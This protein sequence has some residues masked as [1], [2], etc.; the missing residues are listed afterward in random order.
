M[1]S[2]FRLPSLSS[3][4]L[5]LARHSWVVFVIAVVSQLT[6]V[7]PAHAAGCP[8]I[9]STHY[10]GG[11]KARA[12]F[13]Y[14]EAFDS[15]DAMTLEAWVYREDSGRCETIISHDYTKSW[16]LGFCD[17]LRFYRNGS[18]AD[19]DLDVPAGQWTHVAASYDGKTVRFFI[20]GTP[21]G[22]KPLQSLG[23]KVS[24][25]VI[26]GADPNGYA[27][28]GSLDEIRLWS[29]ARSA[30]EIQAGMYAELRGQPGLMA[31]WDTGGARE[32]VSNTTVLPG[33]GA[34][35]QVLGILPR[36]L[37][38]PRAAGPLTV[39]GWPK[40]DTEYIGAERLVIRYRD[41]PTAVDLVASLVY[42]DEPNDRALY[43]GL[44]G[45]RAPVNVKRNASFVGVALDADSSRDK[46]AQPA[47]L[48]MMALLD[49]ATRSY[50]G[51]GNGGWTEN[52][53]LS[54]RWAV[55]FSD[56]CS[57]AGNPPCMEFRIPET[58]L[59]SLLETDGLMI[60]HFGIFQSGD[61]FTGPSDASSTSPAT[62]VKATYCDAKPVQAA[63]RISGVVTLGNA[64]LKGVLLALDGPETRATMT[65]ESGKYSFDDLPVG[66]YRVLPILVGYEFNPASADLPGVK[67]DRV[68]N[69][70]AK[71]A[72]A[73]KPVLSSQK[74]SGTRIQFDKRVY[75]GGES[76]NGQLVLSY[77]GA[78]TELHAFLVATETGDVELMTLKRDAGSV[79]SYR[80]A[81]GVPTQ[82]AGSG[83]Y[84]GK[85]TVK[86]GEKLAL[87]YYIAEDRAHPPI[88]EQIVGDIAFVLDPNF[89]GAPVVLKPD[90]AVSSDE[91]TPPEGGK[92]IGTLIARNGWPV[93]LPV[94]ELIVTPRDGD[95]LKR[96]LEVT[97][98]T[99]VA[100]DRGPQ[101][102]PDDPASSYLVRVPTAK[103][104]LA[105][106]RQVRAFLGQQ[107]EVYGSNQEVLDLWSTALELQLKGFIV[108]ANPR[109]QFHDVPGVPSTESGAGDTAARTMQNEGPMNVPQL[110]AF[111]ALWDRDEVRVPVG[112]LDVG[113]APSPDLR[114][115][116]AECD[117]EAPGPGGM[118]CGPGRAFGAQRV[119]N[120]LF[121][122]KIWHGTGV[123]TTLGGKLN[124]RWTP[125]DGE[126][127]GR[128]GV[129]GQVVQP[130]LYQYGLGSYVFE[131]GA[132]MRQ[133]TIDGASVINISGGYPCRIVDSLGIGFN[134]CSEG[135]RAALCT[136]ATA[137]LATASA[138]VCAAAGAT[139]AIPFVGP[140]L[141]IPL[142]AACAVATGAT[143]AASSACFATL[144]LGDPRD[145]MR[146]GVRFAT[147]RGVAVVVS[148]GNRLDSTVLPPVIR[149]LINFSNQSIDDW[150]VFPAMI[151]PCIVAGAVQDRMPFAN[152]HFFGNRVNIWAPIVSPYYRPAPQETI[153][154]PNE[155]VREYL[156]GTSGA[157]PYVTGTIAAMQAVNPALNPRNPALSPRQRLAIPGLIRGIL[158]NSAWTTAELAAMTSDPA[159]AAQVTAGAPQRRH[160]INPLRAVQ[161]AAVGVI[162][163]F[164]P[165]G[166]DTRMNF[167][168][169]TPDEAADD[170]DHARALVVGAGQ[171]ATIIN[172]RG[173]DGA[174][175]RS[176][177][178]W[179]RFTVPSSPGLYVGRVQLMYPTGFGD[180]TLD[181]LR[182][183]SR[184][185]V[186]VET[187]L[188]FETLAV[189]Q[190]T[191]V[192][193]PVHGIAGSDNVYKIQLLETRFAGAAPLAD[194][195]DTDVASN[196]VRP[197]NNDRAR[198]VP[199]GDG[200]VQNWG[201]GGSGPLDA[202]Q[203][204]DV[205]NLSFN[206]TSDVDWFRIT[207]FPEIGGCQ[208]SLEIRFPAGVRCTVYGRTARSNNAVIARGTVSPLVIPT[209]TLPFPPV[210]LQFENQNP[211]S[212][213]EYNFQVRFRALGE[214]ICA[215]VE[216][217]QNRGSARGRDI[218][219]GGRFPFP[220][221]A[222][223]EFSF[224]LGDFLG[225]PGR[226]GD[227]F[228]RIETP[229]FHLFEWRGG[230]DFGADIEVPG[231]ASLRVRLLDMEGK[232]LA[233][234]M[235]P[236]LLGEKPGAPDAFPGARTIALRRASLAPGSY[237]LELSQGTYGI[238]IGLSLPR[239]AIRDGSPGLEDV[240]ASLRL[241]PP[242]LAGLAQTDAAKGTMLL[243]WPLGDAMPLLEES[244]GFE[245]GGLWRASQAPVSADDK[246][247]KAI[248][249]R[250]T[251]TRFYRLRAH[252]DGC[253]EPAL[254]APG[255]RPNPWV[256]A[257]HKFVAY[258]E[259]GGAP[260]P[261]NRVRVEGSQAGVDVDTLL[262]VFLPDPCREVRIEFTSQSGLVDFA[263]YDAAGGV[264][265]TERVLGSA[266]SRRSV[267]LRTGS[268]DIV[269][270]QVLSPNAR[271]VVQKICCRNSDLLSGGAAADEC[272]DFRLDAV[273]PVPNPLETAAYKIT[274]TVSPSVGSGLDPNTRIENE[275]GFTGYHVQYR[276][277]VEFTRDATAVKIDFV[278]FSGLVE[279]QAFDNAGLMVDSRTFSGVTGGP[280]TVLLG[281]PGHTVRRVSIVSPNDRLYLLRLC[282]E[283]VAG[284]AGTGGAC[285]DLRGP[286]GTKP[287]PYAV[288]GLS[289]L[290]RIPSGAPSA[291]NSVLP[292]DGEVGVEI[293]G[294]STE[295]RLPA[296][297]N[298]VTLKLAM[299]GGRF[300]I[301]A[302]DPGFRVVDREVVTGPGPRIVSITLRGPAITRVLL[303]SSD[304]K[305]V[306]AEVCCR[307]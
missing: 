248:V 57:G 10:D 223:D 303:K 275:A 295:I 290:R 222:P 169:V 95:D 198:S 48:L 289:L 111:L 208:P 150:Q 279:F 175:D 80:S 157:A 215:L 67:S 102:G 75:A 218:F 252:P 73:S 78:I 129:G 59:G 137:V 220:D 237:M 304:A 166:Y 268:S 22:E 91:L 299:D 31:V 173:E 45:V 190:A 25:P 301:E 33:S 193:F 4:V 82:G 152:L 105:A 147:D 60:G 209:A 188:T 272:H 35:E 122:S 53:S 84:D 146:D 99:V 246:G 151:E 51:N 86:P 183:V 159:V 88:D 247:F 1:N 7:H 141:A 100:A 207:S 70:S 228:G 133:A 174:P 68:A 149:D 72:D 232:L 65:D 230:G 116:L 103:A 200:G 300:D 213:K 127:G 153:T 38:I 112:I 90:V 36:D 66:D 204:I 161:R 17:R 64:P 195:F 167:N 144:L 143:V 156:G 231:N 107:D 163:D 278:Q 307:E 181:G 171:T 293:G 92:R 8:P 97:K 26:V 253:V 262:A 134:I 264:V 11:A 194:R 55:K 123:A 297:C 81:T 49:T 227:P 267:T 277:D 121:G 182:L 178:D 139:A 14:Q 61:G 140:F 87:M 271:T 176:D 219:S 142:F 43:I 184:E 155:W 192:R 63:P 255:V 172:I 41:G 118:A 158:T 32:V 132:G 235:T 2:P 224:K 225:L 187:R 46:A 203:E 165:L 261:F 18:R 189:Y 117:M 288:G 281:A 249:P 217:N 239:N 242:P 240:R 206:S 212:P 283:G 168:E 23:P 124:N 16:W 79:R 234:A 269:S 229:E 71:K 197:N 170:R 263:A 274:S 106:L 94:D 205:R 119:G 243:E 265:A 258:K 39:D 302:Q 296:A 44:T 160:L 77:D 113:F 74:P 177:V 154:P 286:A 40:L 145:P 126:T 260:S 280:Q 221:P 135:G 282:G 214:L 131:F 305:G 210:Y 179:W 201:A 85:L 270:V 34:V 196:P 42:R 20:N 24:A 284:V 69:F 101:S 108:A 110:W 236:D 62:W 28:Q 128:A 185:T 114:T 89:Q 216:A 148:S 259:V 298:E 254:F 13:K 125:A 9:R 50:V 199:L 52:A 115:P 306:L 191:D 292:R 244:D 245:F 211:E 238:L 164:A 276:S 130:L 273:G 54:N 15:T 83:L 266:P 6:M 3:R 98:G 291:S 250:S 186:G 56:A 180:L 12:E 294:G 202:Y 30:A 104:N 256:V 47:D 96:F 138:A 251:T 233:E 285:V 58:T 93:Q 162:P 37:M 120:S 136:A 19:S 21:A 241:G 5:S 29:S 226:G 27:F 76:V 109:I 287:N 257:G